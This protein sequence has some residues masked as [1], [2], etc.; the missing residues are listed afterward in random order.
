MAII[1]SYPNLPLSKLTSDDLLV[2][3]D[4]DSANNNPTKSVTLADLATYVTNTGTGTG[5]TNK[6]TKWTN[7]A[8]G[9]LGDSCLLYTSPSP[10]DRG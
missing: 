2:I 8:S 3:T 9:I 7:G 10:R 6:I 4:I 5:T 1:Y